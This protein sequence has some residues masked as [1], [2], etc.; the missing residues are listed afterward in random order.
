MPLISAAGMA[1]HDVRMTHNSAVAPFSSDGG[2]TGILFC[3]GFTGSPAA[4]RPWAE[5]MSR[6]GYSTRL[7]LLPGHGTTPQELATTGWQDWRDAERSA[8]TELRARC[9]R[10][11]VFGLSMGGTLALRLAEELG[12][13][14]TGLALVN[15]SVHTENPLA[16]LARL[17]QYVKPM[18]PAIGNDIKRPGGNEHAYDRMPVKAFVQL[19]QLWAVV[20]ADVAKVDQPTLIVKSAEDHVVEASNHEWLVTH[21]PAQDKQ[22]LILE[23]SYHVAT[24][25]NDADLLFRRSLEFVQRVVRQTS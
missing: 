9:D 15:A 7:P 14:V 8:F 6:H 10:V 2:S 23:H 12:D 24:L 17:L 25:D 13:D 11:F 1:C 3:H 4:M 16:R 21:I 18:F 20:R 5:F 22:V 19:Q